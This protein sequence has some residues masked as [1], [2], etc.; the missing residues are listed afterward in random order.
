MRLIGT[1][2]F[3]A[4]ALIGTAYSQS[5]GSAA[6]NTTAAAAPLGDAEIQQPRN[7][8]IAYGT[9]W[10]R[11]M[12]FGETDERRAIRSCGRIIGERIT[13]WHT[14]TALYNR[15]QHYDEIGEGS[16]AERDLAEALRLFTDSIGAYPQDP[17]GYINRATLFEYTERYDE[18]L[19]DYERA[20]AT[21]PNLGH[22]HY[23]RGAIFFNQGDYASAPAEY[24][25]ASRKAPEQ[26]YYHAA[27]CEGRAAAGA[28]WETARAACEEAIRIAEQDAYV[29]FSRG[30]FR[31]R[32]G[33]YAGALADFSISVER[34]AESA[35]GLYGRGVAAIRLGRH[36]EGQ[37]DIDRGIAL[38]E[39]VDEFYGNA[40]L[41]P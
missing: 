29:Y 30:F 18:A 20:S 28:D 27:R 16:A 21:D 3:L 4:I 19:A 25:E 12:G 7:R 8:R 22:P 13:R 1:A 31:F 6:G 38:D 5:A 37:A 15:A 2:A 24:D 40:G 11:C 34:N 39:D 35:P 17:Y 41:R 36:A 26:P 33:D 32:Q 14:A 10:V 9:H 23:R